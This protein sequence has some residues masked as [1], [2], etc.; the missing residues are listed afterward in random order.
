M[1]IMDMYEDMERVKRCVYCNKP[2]ADKVFNC[3]KKHIYH[4]RCLKVK[5]GNCTFC[6]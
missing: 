3:K 1:D 2:N 5:D 6:K 4:G